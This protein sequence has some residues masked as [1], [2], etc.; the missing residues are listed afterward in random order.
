MRRLALASLLAVLTLAMAPAAHAVHFLYNGFDGRVFQFDVALSPV[1]STFDPGVSFDLANVMVSDS[2]TNGG[3]PYADTLRFVHSGQVNAFVVGGFN[4][5]P[6]M[7]NLFIDNPQLYTGPESAPTFILTTVRV[8]QAD[9]ENGTNPVGMLSITDG[10][11]AAP[12]P[13]SLALLGMGLV[14]LGVA[15]R[16]RRAA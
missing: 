16:R 10:G 12:E 13:A 3:T 1:P 2:L 15:R 11:V 8:S 6:G 4:N 14:G 7:N 5:V 9:G